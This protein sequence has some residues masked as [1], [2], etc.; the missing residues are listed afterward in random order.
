MVMMTISTI[1]RKSNLKN[2]SKQIQR[3]AVVRLRL[4]SLRSGILVRMLISSLR[5]RLIEDYFGYR[6]T[7]IEA[8]R[9][10]AYVVQYVPKEFNININESPAGTYIYQNGMGVIYPKTDHHLEA[11][12]RLKEM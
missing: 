2:G 9:I 6:D 7:Q 12:T 5:K 4:V 10:L 8:V 1:A 3:I 11:L